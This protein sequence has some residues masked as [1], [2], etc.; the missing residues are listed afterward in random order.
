MTALVIKNYGHKVEIAMD[1]AVTMDNGYYLLENERKFFTID[2]EI[3]VA[4]MGQINLLYWTKTCI[5]D[6]ITAN[7]HIFGSDYFT[8]IKHCADKICSRLERT[9][10]HNNIKTEFSLI[11]LI[12]QD[13]INEEFK[14]I[15]FEQ[16]LI[17]D[18]H[19]FIWYVTEKML[20]AY[21]EEEFN[22]AYDL[23]K[24]DFTNISANEIIDAIIVENRKMIKNNE[25]D[26]YCDGKVHTQSICTNFQYR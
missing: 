6:Q 5:V 13:H 20:I 8:L 16:K 23:V 19:S 17:D 18:C 1:S 12:T 11:Y 2:D 24:T 25:T 15:V 4:C 10:T 14:I 26:I 22:R 9:F 3:L 7:E 21:P